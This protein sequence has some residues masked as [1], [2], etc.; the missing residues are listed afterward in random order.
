MLARSFA[1]Y[2]NCLRNTTVSGRSR[3]C[4]ALIGI[5]DA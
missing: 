5:V 2:M 3:E 1:R 4:Y